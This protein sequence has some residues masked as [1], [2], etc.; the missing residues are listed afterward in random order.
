MVTFAPDVYNSFDEIAALLA[1]WHAAHPDLADLESIGQTLDGKDLWLLTLTDKATGPHDTKPAFWCDGNTHA[2]EVTG[3]QACLHL[4]HT[5]L[6]KWAAGDAWVKDVL[7]TSTVY[8]LPR[9]SADGAEYMLTTPYSCRSSP[10]LPPTSAELP[11][12]EPDDVDGD[13][14]VRMMRQVDP[15]GGYK[16]SRLDPR[17]MI[18]RLPHERDPAE[19]YY[20]LFPEGSYR[21]YDG[22]TQAAADTAFS[23]DLN[24]Q[25][26]YRYAPEGEQA[27]AGPYPGYLP[28]ARHCWEAVTRR[29]NICTLQSYHTSGRMLLRPDPIPADAGVY[30]VR[31][32]LHHLA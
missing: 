7:A 10:V 21:D 28:Q 18:Q 1:S 20:R 14:C 17:M 24:R 6:E 15:S 4:V 2:G 12:F 13:G 5:L 22:F 31:R 16:C 25:W 9:I 26:P 30:Q 8:V 27:G 32:H 23:L 11:G 19:T 3:A 29:N